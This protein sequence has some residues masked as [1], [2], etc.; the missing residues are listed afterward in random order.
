ME[1]LGRAAREGRHRKPPKHPTGSE[2]RARLR[3]Q[4]QQDAAIFLT[5]AFAGLRLGELRSLRW[6]DLDFGKRLIRIRHS[7]VMR[8]EDAPKSGRVRSVPM[9]DQVA[10]AL[11]GLSRRDGWTGAD[12]L[13]F[14]SHAGEYIED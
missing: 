12:D 3:Q 11:D 1:A 7:Y 14:V 8:H 10:R 6:R 9:T 13:V 5:A 4:D 2:W